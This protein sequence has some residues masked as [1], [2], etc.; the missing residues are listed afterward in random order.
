VISC[1]AVVYEQQIVKSVVE[2]EVDNDAANTH[3][4]QYQP[5]M[6]YH[7]AP[8]NNDAVSSFALALVPDVSGAIS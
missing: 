3:G 1:R 4:R 7:V 5:Y 2:D 8:A 6:D